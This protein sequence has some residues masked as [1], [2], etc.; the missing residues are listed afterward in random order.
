[1]TGLA[2]FAVAWTVG[3]IVTSTT[4]LRTISDDSPAL[5]FAFAMVAWPIFWIK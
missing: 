2:L 5:R 4:R 3:A 1:M